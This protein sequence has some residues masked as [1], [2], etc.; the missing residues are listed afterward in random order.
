MLASELLG[1]QEDN[2]II[3]EGKIVNRSSSEE[4]TFEDIV[5]R[6]GGSISGEASI[7]EGDEIPYMSFTAHIA[8]V[9][10]DPGTGTVWLKR[11]TA[12]HETGKVVNPQGFTAQIEGG[13]IQGIGH[14]LMEEL[15]A[16]DGRIRSLC[17]R[18]WA[19]I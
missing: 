5:S 3:R 19:T 16:E 7:D 18:D 6:T 11:Y 12:A 10:I 13:V 1:W 14:S 4:V 15:T 9:E 2:L 17:S 8:E